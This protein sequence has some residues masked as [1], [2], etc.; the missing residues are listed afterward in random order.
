MNY[1]LIRNNMS[2]HG[3]FK[4]NGICGKKEK[5]EIVVDVQNFCMFTVCD[6]SRFYKGN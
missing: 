3:N 5:E 4:I 1:Q 6:S 2:N